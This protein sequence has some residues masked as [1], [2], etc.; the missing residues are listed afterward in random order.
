[1]NVH[2]NA[3]AEVKKAEEQ[4]TVE[5]DNELADLRSV[6]KTPAGRR[7]LWRILCHCKTFISIW[8]PSAKIHWNAGRQDVGH[9][10][11]QEIESADQEALLT[12][13]REAK[14]AK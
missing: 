14:G 2:A 7:V 4:A 9:F 1:V 10:V 13:M 12:M 5:R 3:E 8:E 6:L 11:I